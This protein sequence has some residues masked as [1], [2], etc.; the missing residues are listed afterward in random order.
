MPGLYFPAT[1]SGLF[2]FVAVDLPQRCIHA[3]PL[4]R[5]IGYTNMNHHLLH[6]VGFSLPPNDRT[7]ILWTF[8]APSCHRTRGTFPSG[9]CGLTIRGVGGHSQVRESLMPPW[10]AFNCHLNVIDAPFVCRKQDFNFT[11]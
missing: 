11:I 9:K 1:K 10:M 5:W 4:K 2:T 3:L 6:K 8:Y 7:C